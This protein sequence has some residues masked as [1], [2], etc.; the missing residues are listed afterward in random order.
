M[1]QSNT[2]ENENQVSIQFLKIKT[3]ER[4]EKLIYNKIV[5]SIIAVGDVCAI[6]LEKTEEECQS[7]I[8]ANEKYH[9]ILCDECGSTIKEKQ[10]I[11]EPIF[12]AISNDFFLLSDHSS[13]YFWNHN[14]SSNKM[15]EKNKL[16]EDYEGYF[17]ISNKDTKP[18]QQKLIKKENIIAHLVG[19]SSS[20]SSDRINFICVKSSCFLVSQTSGVINI[21]TLPPNDISL[22]HTLKLPETS[23]FHIFMDMNCNNSKVAV[24]D[25]N[26]VLKIITIDHQNHE[27]LNIG[28]DQLPKQ[29]QSQEKY[30]NN[31]Q[32]KDVWKMRWSED[33]PSSL[34]ILEKSNLLIIHDLEDVESYHIDDGDSIPFGGNILEYKDF[35]V[36]AIKNLDQILCLSSSILNNVS[37]LNNARLHTL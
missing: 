33:N 26:N 11:I 31:F 15:A 9:V 18:S 5:R 3:N 4:R 25:D 10:T 37:S 20:S 8:L 16:A 17:D 34:V 19:A 14:S 35:K 30:Y 36:L 29:Q 28:Y 27:S 22:L 12:T 13:I 7:S 1:L 32:K 24:I 6:V 21:Y 2:Y 23:P